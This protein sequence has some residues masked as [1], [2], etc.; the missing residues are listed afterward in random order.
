MLAAFCYLCLVLWFVAH[1]RDFQYAPGGTSGSPEAVGLA[2][3]AEVHIPTEDDERIVGWWAHHNRGRGCRPLGR[4]GGWSKRASS[5]SAHRVDCARPTATLHALSGPCRAASSPVERP[6]L[7]DARAVNL[8]GQQVSDQK[9][10]PISAPTVFDLNPTGAGRMDRLT[11][12]SQTGR[13]I[14]ALDLRKSCCTNGLAQDQREPDAD[15]V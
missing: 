6:G 1:Q 4:L 11:E 2:G 10:R 14:G 5:Q 9:H 12:I 15:R 8:A 3:F 13:C 7:T